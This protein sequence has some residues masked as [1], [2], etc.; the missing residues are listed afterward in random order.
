MLLTACALL[1]SPFSP[2]LSAATSKWSLCTKRDLCV[3][4][5]QFWRKPFTFSFAQG[6]EKMFHLWFN[7]FFIDNLVFSAPQPEID[8]VG[9]WVGL[10]RPMAPMATTFFHTSQKGQQGQEEQDLSQG[11]CSRDSL[12][13]TRGQRSVRF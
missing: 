2:H 7:T 10:L 1:L 12:H 11:L 13:L 8:K 3:G 5:R 9:F 6:K 4:Q